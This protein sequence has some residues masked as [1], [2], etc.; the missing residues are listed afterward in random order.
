MRQEQTNELTT[1][2]KQAILITML[3]KIEPKKEGC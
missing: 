2:E 1:A 3:E